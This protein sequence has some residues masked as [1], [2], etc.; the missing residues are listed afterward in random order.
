MIFFLR[1]SSFREKKTDKGI[2]IKTLLLYFKSIFVVFLKEERKYIFNQVSPIQM[3]IFQKS[4]IKKCY[5]NSRVIFI[6]CY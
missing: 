5:F 4:D 1:F 3:L 2:V 6:F